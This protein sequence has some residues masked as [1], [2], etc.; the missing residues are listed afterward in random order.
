MRP[1]E[2]RRRGGMLMARLRAA[3][4]GASSV[5]ARGDVGAPRH[6][7]VDAPHVEILVDKRAARLAPRARAIVEA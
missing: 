5:A 4:V 3:R 6:A 2:V 1:T 7:R